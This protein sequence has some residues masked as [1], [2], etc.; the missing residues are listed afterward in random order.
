MVEVKIHRI[1][2]N[3]ELPKYAKQGDAAFDLRSSE[4]KIL[5]SGDKHIVKTGIRLAIPEG[6]VGLVWDRSGVA[7]KHGVHCMA[8]VIDSGYRGEVGVVMKNLSNEDFT[9][10]K[11]MRIAQML[12]QPVAAAKITEVEELEETE[13]NSGGFGSTGLK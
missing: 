4:D 10:E 2:K 7:A 13:R 3:V 11:N 5:K 8:G 6:Y 12:I 1:D 9:I